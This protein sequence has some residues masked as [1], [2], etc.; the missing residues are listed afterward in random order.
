MF[1]DILIL[2][3]IMYDGSSELADLSLKL[4]NRNLSLSNANSCFE[5]A[6]CVFDSMTENDGPKIVEVIEVCT[7]LIF[8]DVLPTKKSLSPKN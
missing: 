3:G 5:C 6:V 1:I 2:L 4:Q 8:K 7:K